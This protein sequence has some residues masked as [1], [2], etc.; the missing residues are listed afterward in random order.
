V[1]EF[2]SAKLGNLA[3]DRAISIY[4]VAPE[5]P[6]AQDHEKLRKKSLGNYESPAL[7]AEL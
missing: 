7:T 2:Y 6:A 1:R 3:T 5:K 4:R